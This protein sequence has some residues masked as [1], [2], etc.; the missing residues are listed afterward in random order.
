MDCRRRMRGERNLKALCQH[1][2]IDEASDA[3]AASSISLQYIH[4]A[5]FQQAAEIILI[6]SVFARG[7]FHSR[8]DAIANQP[9]TF[10][11][12]RGNR[13]FEPGNLELGKSL[14][15]G[16]R[17]FASVCSVGVDEELRFGSD[18][19]A[20]CSD[21]LDVAVGIG[22]HLHLDHANAIGSP[23]AKLALKLT[24]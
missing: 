1:A 13:L 17:L 10:Q 15:H 20:R 22:S 4:G 5:R 23:S 18:G 14:S 21:S 11:I 19:L 16:Q 2:S 3:R 6:I 8:G 9:Q 7:D 24:N 12:V